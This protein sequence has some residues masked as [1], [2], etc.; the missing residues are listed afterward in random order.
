MVIRSY[1]VRGIDMKLFCQCNSTWIVTPGYESR[2][3][4]GTGTIERKTF[5]MCPECGYYFWIEA[6][7]ENMMH[8]LREMNS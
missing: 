3:I 1:A 5:G 7:Y 2:Q 4:N 6:D 8:D